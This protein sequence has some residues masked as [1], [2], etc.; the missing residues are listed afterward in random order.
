MRSALVAAVVRRVLALD[1]RLGRID[2]AI[3]DEI[4]RTTALR[5]DSIRS[6]ERIDNLS[7][8]VEAL[9]AEVRSLSAKYLVEAQTNEALREALAAYLRLGSGSANS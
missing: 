2:C 6:G 5:A 3:R 4:A 9:R 1:T 8:L 7:L